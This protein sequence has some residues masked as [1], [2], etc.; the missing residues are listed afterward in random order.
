MTTILLGSILLERNRWAKDRAASIDVAAWAER[1]RQAGFDGLEVWENHVRRGAEE[2][3]ERL[4][5]GGTPVPVFNSYATCRQ[6]GADDRAAAA[7]WARRLKCRYVKFNFSNDEETLDEEIANLA[8]WKKQMA[9]AIPLCE[10]HPHTAADTPEK[11]RAVLDAGA[12]GLC[13]FIMHPFLLTP[14]EI[15]A[16]FDVL[17]SRIVHLHSQARTPTP[18]SPDFIRLETERDRIIANLDLVRSLGFD[19]SITVEFTAGVRDRDTPTNELWDS[20]LAD[21]KL[22]QDWRKG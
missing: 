5:A 16:W 20:A 10:A 3:G 12:D 15:G 4:A 6:A 7:D 18:D 19:G 14:E 21:L 22:L 13:D 9:P 1:A 17:G 2:V 11:A 8:E